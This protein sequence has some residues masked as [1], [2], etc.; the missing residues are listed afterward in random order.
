MSLR[1]RFLLLTLALLLLLDVA[2]SVYA[3]LGAQTPSRLWSP[4]PSY[5]QAIAWPPGS[6]LPADAPM[7]LR[8]YAEHCAVCH[9]PE[10][11][12]NG[13]AAPSLHPRPR[14]FSGGVFKLKSTPPNVPPTRADV[15]AT[16]GRG[17]PGTSMPGWQNLLSEDEI[18]AVTD[19]IRTLG[20]LQAWAPAESAPTPPAALL[21][22][23]SAERGHA[24]YT[25]LGCPACHGPEGRG[26]GA[27]AKDLR[28]VWKQP[29][30]PRDLTAPWTFHGGDRPDAL[31]AR[32]AYGQGGTP[33]PGYAEVA[34]PAQIADV[35]AYIRSIARPPAWNA[36]GSFEG[37]GQSADPVQ[38]GEY[39]VRA[40]MCG[41]CHTPVDA[42]G[43]YLANTHYLAGGMKV[44]AGA[45]G[46]FFSANLTP[47]PETGLGNWSVEQIAMAVRTGH[48]PTRRLNYWAMPWMVFAKLTPEDSTAIARFLKTLPPVRNLV[49]PPLHYGLVE[50]V[51]RKLTY[52]WPAVVPPRLAYS[53]GNFGDE[54]PARWRRD[55]PQRVLIWVQYVVLGVGLLLFGLLTVVAPAGE[56]RGLGLT[57][58]AIVASIVGAIAVAVVY[59]YP[60]LEMLPTDSVTNAFFTGLPSAPMEGR[61][62]HEAAVLQRGRYLY[63]IASCAYCHGSDGAGGNK[64]NW[65]VFGTTWERNLT[66]HPTGLAD[67]PDDDVL[68][69]MVSGVSR[70]GRAVHWQ[71]MIW[72]HLSNY[73]LE[74]QH[75]LLAFVRSL[76][77]LERARPA[78][79]PPG[80]HDCAA[81][82][83]WLGES[84]TAA[85]CN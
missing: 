24:L 32:I 9:G 61:A 42:N 8:L 68:R 63:S 21:A 26:D 74:D 4:D 65:S 46:V 22:A 53:A 38:R 28:D 79:L 27:S 40:G 34:E 48:T 35:V 18:G 10:G 73:A 66:A 44:D 7:G 84:D 31:Y 64:V 83:F 5:A 69:A 36:G 25:D 33:M 47:D 12:G 51:A 78:P 14:D 11:H 37:P 39:L 52:R 1:S 75:A 54:P 56:E 77:P 23:A 41:L 55:L 2:R 13:P 6:N 60:A 29:V 50:T 71:A 58:L 15:I 49:P 62:P 3:R 80:T 19:H 81:D 30:R 45:H 57:F 16:I 17:I 85:G 59:R 70:T 43:I 76:P 72:D 82:T 20:P 67:W